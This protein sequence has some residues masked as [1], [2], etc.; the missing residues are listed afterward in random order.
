MQTLASFST[1]DLE[2]L[3]LTYKRNQPNYSKIKNKV[4]GL[5]AH[6]NY[7]RTRKSSLFFFGALT[8]I[9]IISSSFSL[10]AQD[11]NSFMALWLIWAIAASVFTTWFAFYYRTNAHVLQ[12]NE[13]FFNKFETVAQTSNSLEDFTKNWI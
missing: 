7:K 4:I 5:D 9:I 13:A 2:R 11:T 6:S 12:K 8:F 1:H 10:V 3:F